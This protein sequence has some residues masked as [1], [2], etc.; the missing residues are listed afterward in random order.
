MVLFIDFPKK[1]IADLR[2][3]GSF[4]GK[5]GDRLDVRGVSPIA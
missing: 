2:M 3:L 4:E 1:V 5:Q